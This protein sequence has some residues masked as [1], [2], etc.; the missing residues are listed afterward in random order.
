MSD[1]LYTHIAFTG[2]YRS[3]QYPVISPQ[4]YLAGDFTCLKVDLEKD[5][6]TE[7]NRQPRDDTKKT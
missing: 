3:L 7:K 4:N 2:I 6:C 1:G 5:M